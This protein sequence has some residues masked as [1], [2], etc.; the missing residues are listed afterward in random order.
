[1]R[2]FE[3]RV[4]ALD[5]ALEAVERA[6]A[7][8]QRARA[9]Y[10]SEHATSDGRDAVVRALE[11]SLARDDIDEASIERM[12]RVQRTLYRMLADVRECAAC[13]DALAVCSL[14]AS[15]DVALATLTRAPRVPE[16]EPTLPLLVN[17]EP[18][19]RTAV[20]AEA[21]DAA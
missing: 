18:P 1:M 15:A 19:T 9:V 21:R 11:R 4:R 2:S 6:L 5:D 12:S 20:R 13:G 14:V 3:E 16:H 17:D 10:V 7:A 8:R